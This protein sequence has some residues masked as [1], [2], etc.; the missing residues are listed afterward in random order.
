MNISLCV[1]FCFYVDAITIQKH[2]SI[3]FCSRFF[4]FFITH[5]MSRLVFSLPGCSIVGNGTFCILS[6]ERNFQK[7]FMAFIR[8][9]TRPAQERQG[10]TNDVIGALKYRTNVQISFTKAHCGHWCVF[11]YRTLASTHFEPTSA[12]MAFP[13]FD[14]PSFKAN[15]SIRIWRSPKYISLSN[16]PVVSFGCHHASESVLLMCVIHGCS[17]FFVVRVWISD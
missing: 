11:F 1:L 8:A 2:I 13:C 9:H 14:E 4:Q 10:Q 17:D 3:L 15:F 6:L 5:P 12:R 16:M 7:D